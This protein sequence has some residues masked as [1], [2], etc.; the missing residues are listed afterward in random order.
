MKVKLSK[1]ISGPNIRFTLWE[2]G[3]QTC[4]GVSSKQY[5]TGV[6]RIFMTSFSFPAI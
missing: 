4:K 2:G 1:C 5:L 6:E 3:G